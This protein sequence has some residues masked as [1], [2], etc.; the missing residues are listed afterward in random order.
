MGGAHI[1]SARLSS[2]L[3]LLFFLVLNRRQTS[4]VDCPLTSGFFRKRSPEP[5]RIVVGSRKVRICRSAPLMARTATPSPSLK[6]SDTISKLSPYILMWREDA[7]PRS[8]IL[9]QRLERVRSHL[10]PSASTAGASSFP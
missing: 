8:L 5:T 10:S 4:S 7:K 3:V 6:G 2:S 1:C 9:A